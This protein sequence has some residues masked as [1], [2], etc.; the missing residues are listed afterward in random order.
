MI[1]GESKAIKKFLGAHTC[2]TV[3]M[4]EL[5]GIQDAL[6]YALSQNQSSGV[7]IFA[8][9]QA[10]LQALENPNGCSAPQIMQKITRRIDDLRA[11]GTPIHLHWI[12]AHTDIAAKETTGLRR[13]KRRNGRWRERDSGYTAERH[14][15]GRA[16]ATIK[17]ALEQR[18]LGLGE[19][20]WSSEKT[21]RELRV[22][23][24]KPT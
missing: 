8:D 10:A 19:Q 12:P 2:S 9:S 22:I 1:Q 14:V 20:A 13:A 3:Y 21:G 15:L 4:G 6:S 11:K 16:R 23:C 24:P 7:R 17:L 5:Q 18:T